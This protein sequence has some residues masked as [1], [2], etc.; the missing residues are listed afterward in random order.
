MPTTPAINLKVALFN[1]LETKIENMDDD[2]RA[3][4]MAFRKAAAGMP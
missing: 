2:I 3:E 1:I 4:I